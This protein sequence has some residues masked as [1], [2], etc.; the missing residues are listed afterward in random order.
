MMGRKR[1]QATMLGGRD[2]EREIDCYAWLSSPAR[3][4][5]VT[6]TSLIVFILDERSSSYGRHGNGDTGL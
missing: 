5:I 2:L 3:W 6:L 4:V 1:N